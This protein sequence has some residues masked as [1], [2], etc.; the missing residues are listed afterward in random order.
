MSK[1]F[2][3]W[4]ESSS[5]LIVTVINKA[6][7]FPFPSDQLRTSYNRLKFT[8][9]CGFILSFVLLQSRLTFMDLTFLFTVFNCLFF[10]YVKQ[11]TCKGNSNF[12]YKTWILNDLLD[13]NFQA[14]FKFARNHIHCAQFSYCIRENNLQHLDSLSNRLIRLVLFKIQLL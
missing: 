13:F 2:S 4:C 5:I 1:R 12:E 6:T 10:P 9:N 14:L 7:T 11:T 8:V 3:W